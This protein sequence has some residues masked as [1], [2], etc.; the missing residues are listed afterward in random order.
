[1]IAKIFKTIKFLPILI[2]IFSLFGLHSVLAQS[3]SLSPSSGTLST[4]SQTQINIIVTDP[5][6]TNGATVHLL[7][8]SPLKVVSA[9]PASGGNIL[10]SFGCSTGGAS[11]ND[12]EVCF[13][14]A[15]TS[16]FAQNQQIGSF[17]VQG[18]STGN[19]SISYGPTAEMSDGTNT[20]DLTGT[21]GN[22]TVTNDVLP[23]TSFQLYDY[24]YLL[25]GLLTIDA[26][27]ILFFIKNKNSNTK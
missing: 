24:F 7:V 8:P 19:A 12:N 23:D 13:S 5:S 10:T 15:A 14:I 21:V 9:T 20:Y 22:Y 26:A 6:G 1:M 17:V 25:I 11:F 3:Y 16:V 27:L 2:I 18:E 4:A